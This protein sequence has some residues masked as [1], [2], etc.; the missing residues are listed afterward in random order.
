MCQETKK[1]EQ[2]DCNNKRADSTEEDGLVDTQL[3]PIRSLPT[4]NH[5][6]ELRQMA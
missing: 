6:T 5:K 3:Y 1:Y 2:N 4:T